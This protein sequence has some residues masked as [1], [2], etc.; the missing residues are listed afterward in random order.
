MD[1]VHVRKNYARYAHLGKIMREE[2][3]L[4]PYLFG[5]YWSGR[6]L[7]FIQTLRNTEAMRPIIPMP[8]QLYN[9]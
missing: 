4:Y 8:L 9:R 5:L 1:L 6:H 2:L 7:G 3:I